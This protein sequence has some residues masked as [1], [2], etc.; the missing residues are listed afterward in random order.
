[1]NDNGFWWVICMVCCHN[2]G[3]LS[4]RFVSFPQQ[5]GDSHI[6][7]TRR[8]PPLFN[9]KNAWKYACELKPAPGWWWNH[10]E[11]ET[12]VEM[13]QCD[14]FFAE[15]ATILPTIDSYIFQL[16]GRVVLGV[17]VVWI[18]IRY[19]FWKWLEFLRGIPRLNPKP[20]GTKPPMYHLGF[21]KNWWFFTDSTMA[22]QHFS[23]PFEE[24]SC[25]FCPTTG[26]PS[27][28]SKPLV[29]IVIYI[30]S[31]YP[32]TVPRITVTNK[33]LEGDS[34]QKMVHNQSWWWWW[35]S[36]LTCV[37]GRFPTDIQPPLQV[38]KLM[39]MLPGLPG[40]VKPSWVMMTRKLLMFRFRV[41]LKGFSTRRT[42][43]F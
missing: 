31:I 23:P 2:W 41:F 1:M 6:S 25:H 17:L 37:K 43:T 3:D 14:F 32:L 12:W 16:L 40:V 27:K 19:L 38:M 34:L 28:S 5:V 33:R 39:K 4:K 8:F 10:F 9:L 24:Y 29:E 30:S 42:C 18:P 13:I 35:W 11:P 7:P 26:N 20:S 36:H 21:V 22:N 15:W